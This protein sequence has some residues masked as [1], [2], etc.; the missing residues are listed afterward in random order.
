VT[1]RAPHGRPSTAVPTGF[2]PAT[3]ALTGRRALRCSTGPGRPIVPY[4]A[5]AGWPRGAGA[6]AGGPSSASRARR[7]DEL[8]GLR[9]SDVDLDRRT[10]RTSGRRPI[11]SG[12][13]RSSPGRPGPPR[14]CPPWQCDR[15]SSRA[16]P[17]PRAAGLPAPGGVAAHRTRRQPAT[18]STRSTGQTA[19]RKAVGIAPPPAGTTPARPATPSRPPRTLAPGSSWRARVTPARGRRSATNPPPRRGPAIAAALSGLA[20]PS[21]VSGTGRLGQVRVTC[22]PHEAPAPQRRASASDV[23]ERPNGIRTR[24]AALKGR[25]KGSRDQ[26]REAETPPG[27]GPSR[28]IA[29][30]APGAARPRTRSDRREGSRQAFR[31]YPQ[32]DSNPCRRLERAVSWAARRWGPDGATRRQPALARSA[33]RAPGC[34]SGAAGSRLPG[35]RSRCPGSAPTLPGPRSSRARR[36][37]PGA[38]AG[39]LRSAG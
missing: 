3:S 6:V 39:P 14:A 23:A 32:R 20:G 33:Y 16:R 30:A 37:Q 34:R 15:R 4:R 11:T 26:V 8:V 27:P 25:P 24:A 13:T 31:E 12:T 17:L 7:R 36:A 38:G 5:R 22:G 28:P 9:R 10:V 19:A 2:E 35:R 21:R 1:I 29:I 18:G